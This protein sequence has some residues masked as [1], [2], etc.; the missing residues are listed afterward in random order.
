MLAMALSIFFTFAILQMLNGGEL[1]M[2]AD[3]G[4][5]W[6]LIDKKNVARQF[7]EFICL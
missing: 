2:I 5:K 7:D 6:N 4:K 1:D 3:G